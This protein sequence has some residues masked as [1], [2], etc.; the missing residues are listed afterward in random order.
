MFSREVSFMFMPSEGTW[1]QQEA[2][3]IPVLFCDSSHDSTLLERAPKGRKSLLPR[4]THL[5]LLQ[6]PL[7]Q[8]LLMSLFHISLKIQG[9]K[10]ENKTS[11]T[12][13]KPF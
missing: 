13:L 11:E 6:A 2:A 9:T 4:E 1:Q 10:R 7:C 12:G 5:K 8:V 3:P